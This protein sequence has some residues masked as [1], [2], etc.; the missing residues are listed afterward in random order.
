MAAIAMFGVVAYK[1]LPVADLPTVDSPTIQVQAGVPGDEPASMA[2]SVA[3]PIERQLT[4]IAGIDA[5]TSQRRLGNSQVTLQFDLGRSMDSAVVDVQ[6]ALSEVMPLLPAGMP[7]PPTFRTQNPA[8]HDIMQV[9]L[10]SSSLSMAVLD[11]FAETVLAPRI[12]M[13][14]GVS[15]VQV[16]GAQKYAAAGQVDPDKLRAQQ[17][18]INEVDQAVQNWNVNLP[19]GQ[20]FGPHQTFNIKAGG[21]LNNADEFK[22]I[23]VAYRQGRPVRL[24]QV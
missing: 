3:S 23:I 12:S 24:E 5:M 17:I 10:T 13:V 7:N 1:A 16:N 8:H 14:S 2:S 20:L 11:D 9:S 22:P 19:T 4:T 15:Q 18:G 21:Q 6:T